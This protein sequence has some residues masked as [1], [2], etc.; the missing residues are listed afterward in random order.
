[1]TRITLYS[2]EDCHLCDVA[3]ATLSKVQ[4]SYPFDL[5]IIKIR[6]GKEPFEEFKNRIPVI[7]INGV[8]AFQHRVPED[9]LI[10]KLSLASHGS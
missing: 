10:V 2:K 1:M 4:Q 3:H 5:T 8:F 7:L 6:E 9:E